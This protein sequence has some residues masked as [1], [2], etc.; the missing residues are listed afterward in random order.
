MENPFQ[1]EQIKEKIK[2]TLLTKYGVSHP[3]QSEQ[4]KEKMRE[5]LL[6]KYGVSHPMHDPI[7]RNKAMKK[8][9]KSKDYVFSSG[10]KVRIQGYENFAIDYLLKYILLKI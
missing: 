4:I 7:I 6:T 9:Y 1:S 3:M 8:S 2:E 5:T 10:R